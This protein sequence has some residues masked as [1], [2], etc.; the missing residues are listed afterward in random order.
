MFIYM[1]KILFKPSVPASPVTS[2]WSI[3]IFASEVFL[4]FFRESGHI[5]ELLLPQPLPAV[6]FG[7][8]LL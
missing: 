2:P 4:Y 1:S 3:A 8:A 5:Q 7:S 6:E